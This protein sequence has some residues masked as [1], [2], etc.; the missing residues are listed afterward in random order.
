VRL[1]TAPEKVPD[2][3]GQLKELLAPRLQRLGLTDITQ[4][5]SNAHIVFARQSQLIFVSKLSNKIAYG[6]T[7]TYG[8]TNKVDDNLL[9][10]LQEL[11]PF[12]KVQASDFGRLGKNS[13][14]KIEPKSTLNKYELEKYNE[15]ITSLN[16]GKENNCAEIIINRKEYAFKKVNIDNEETILVWTKALGSYK[17]LKQFN[18]DSKFP[19]K[20][21]GGQVW[22]REEANKSPEDLTNELKKEIDKKT[23]GI[24]FGSWE[25]PKL[26]NEFEKADFEGNVI[27]VSLD[28]PPEI[29]I[30]K[31]GADNFKLP[32]VA[33]LNVF[34]KGLQT[35]RA[36]WESAF[37]KPLDQLGDVVDVA[38][39]QAAGF[40]QVGQWDGL[41]RLRKDAAKFDFIKKGN[42]IYYYNENYLAPIKTSKVSDLKS[43]AT[44][45]FEINKDGELAV[46]E[47]QSSP[48][49]VKGF[50]TK[51][52]TNLNA[53][54]QD[55][56]WKEVNFTVSANKL[57][58]KTK[59]GKPLGTF[60]GKKFKA[61]EHLDCKTENFSLFKKVNSFDF[62]KGKISGGFGGVIK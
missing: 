15:P 25:E 45:P 50:L 10:Y 51:L 13:S 1:K 43:N 14:F 57:V 40:Q 7:G 18:N 20:E 26:E 35:K 49:A 48:E 41:L 31:A 3:V 60:E 6:H 37:G 17:P 9:R 2:I 4:K 47:T 62:Q 28:K 29:A 38:G 30:Q 23:K 34:I 11:E 12:V 46:K 16:P 58:A 5:N 42:D 44:F 8:L 33:G 32:T 39:I 55:D 59:D 56:F 27:I 22:A 53:L 19:F 24:G 52:G 21:V 61:G 36:G 54:K